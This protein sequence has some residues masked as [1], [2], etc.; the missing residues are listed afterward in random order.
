MRWSVP[1]LFPLLP[2]QSIYTLTMSRLR[3]GLIIALSITAFIFGLCALVIPWTYE[4]MWGYSRTKS[5]PQL[6][7]IYIKGPLHTPTLTALQRMSQLIS[8]TYHKLLPNF[9]FQVHRSVIC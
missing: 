3:S 9:S 6:G 1:S 5:T 8:G 7:L 2:S 4:D